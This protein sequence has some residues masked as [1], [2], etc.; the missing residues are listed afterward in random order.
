M[1]RGPAITASDKTLAV[2]D[3]LGE[4]SRL[5]EIAAAA[6]LSKPTTHRILKALAERGYARID[7]K[8]RYSAGPRVLTLAGRLLTQL[9]P[10]EQADDTL[11]RLRVET[12][13]TVHMGAYASDE[14]VY[15]AKID[16]PVPYQMPSRVGMSVRLHATAI[17]KAILA[18]LGDEEASRVCVRTGLE[19]RTPKTITDLR[20]LIAQLAEIRERGYS[21][22]DEENE[23]DIRCVGAAVY[24]HTDRVIGGISLSWLAFNRR[25]RT[26]AELGAQVAAAADEISARLGAP[27][28]VGSFHHSAKETVPRQVGRDDQHHPVDDLLVRD[29]Y[30]DHPDPVLDHGDDARPDDR[31]DDATEGD[32]DG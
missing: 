9:D 18:A 12:G 7:G 21:I 26:L 23:T 11:R 20:E 24:G 8:G 1:E 10:A 16:A 31:A 19:A 2:L 32:R 3:V 15:I 28:R 29:A 4:H 14:V 17:G 25:S 22:D 30:P 5:A 13:L 27:S 6:G